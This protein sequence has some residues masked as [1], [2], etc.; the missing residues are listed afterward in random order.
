MATF[1]QSSSQK[2]RGMGAL[3]RLGVPSRRLQRLNL[4]RAIPSHPTR[5]TTERPVRRGPMPDELDEC[6]TGGLG[7]PGSVQSSPSSFFSLICSSMSSERTS[8][9]RWSFCSRRAILPVLGI[10]GA[11][12]AGFEGGRAV[13]EELLLPAV[14]HRGVDAVLVAQIRDGGVFKEMEPKDGN[15]LL[16][17]ESLASLL[18]HGRTS[19]RNCSL[20][21]RSAFPIPSEAKHGYRACWR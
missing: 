2:S 12:G 7:N 19:A 8:C 1:S 9:L 14:E 21:E 11:S 4:L 16:G 5:S 15:L 18:G 3:C 17:G 20:F 13:L 6:I 10:A